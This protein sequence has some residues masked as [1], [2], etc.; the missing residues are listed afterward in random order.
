MLFDITSN[1]GSDSQ[2]F[3]IEVNP[4]DGQSTQSRQ[5]SQVVQV[6][7][8]VVVGVLQVSTGVGSGVGVGVGVII[9]SQLCVLHSHPQV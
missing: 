3:S 2:V 8:Q 4:V 6:G 5:P 7:V 9:V 1:N